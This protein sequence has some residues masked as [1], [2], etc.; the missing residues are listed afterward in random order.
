MLLSPQYL[1][2]VVANC[3][4]KRELENVHWSSV[5]VQIG[6]PTV[7]GATWRVMFEKMI[8]HCL[9]CG[10]GRLSDVDSWKT[11]HPSAKVTQEG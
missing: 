4:S 9:Y 10:E 7:R 5:P 6:D 11:V 8:G 2:N 3:P 1:E